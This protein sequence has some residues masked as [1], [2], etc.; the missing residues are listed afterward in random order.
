MSSEL[1]YAGAI[2]QALNQAMEKSDSVVVLG[3]LVDSKPGVFG[4]TNGLVDRFGSARVVDFPISESLM[5][6]MSIGLAVNEVRPVLVHQRLD[7][8]L[9]SMDAIANWIS[10]WRFKSGGKES[11]PITIRAIVG[12]GW[13]QG[14]QHSK[15]LYSWFAHLPGVRVGVPSNPVDA[16]GML[17]DSIFGQNP[18]I[19]LEPR[20]LFGMSCPVPK[21]LYR[22]PFGRA[23]IVKTGRDV[24]IV[25]FGNELQICQR[26][27]RGLVDVDAELIDVRSLK[28]LDV[29]TIVSSVQKTGRLL[30]VEGDWQTCGVSSEIITS[31]VESNAVNWKT[32]PQR[33]NYPDSHTP[34]SSQLEKSFYIDEVDVTQAVE[35]LVCD[36]SA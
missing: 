24:T 17:L 14:P 23:R 25:S 4:T 30:V 13:G 18:T 8:S 7:F 16:K 1:T 19:I 28:P 35:E 26:A 11:L 22:T 31:V 15:S 2:N 10:L 6:S 29:V 9:Y 12:K 32:S 36:R 33:L 5:T 27:L 20:A 21:E 34:A 3:Q